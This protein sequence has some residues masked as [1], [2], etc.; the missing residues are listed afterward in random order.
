MSM[1]VTMTLCQVLAE[2]RLKVLYD[3]AKSLAGQP[4]LG[5][6]KAEDGRMWGWVHRVSWQTLT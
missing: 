2:E 3:P 5:T 1:T 6:G 4:R